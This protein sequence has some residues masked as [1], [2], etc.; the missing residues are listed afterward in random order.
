MAQLPYDEMPNGVLSRV[1]CLERPE[2]NGLYEHQHGQ[3]GA[4]QN[5]ERKQALRLRGL[6]CCLHNYCLMNWMF[7]VLCGNFAAASTLIFTPRLL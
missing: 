5:V 6:G 1:C 4:A 2:Q 3:V 7:D